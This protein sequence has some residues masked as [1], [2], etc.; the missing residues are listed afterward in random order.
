MQFGR[1]SRVSRVSP[2]H[3]PGPCW[4]HVR[5]R[6]CW[7]SPSHGVQCDHVS[8]PTSDSQLAIS[9][10]S[11]TN[12]GP[13]QLSGPRH[14]LVLVRTPTPHVVEHS[15]HSVQQDHCPSA[16]LPPPGFTRHGCGL[17][18]LLCADKPPSHGGVSHCLTCK[19]IAHMGVADSTLQKDHLCM[20]A[21]YIASPVKT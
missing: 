9:Q 3:M 17:Q 11:L 18:T 16:M 13:L 21:T 2:L 6:C 14:S 10:V 4:R 19:N 5:F 8:Q 7:W 1:Q 20:V 12:R 15:D